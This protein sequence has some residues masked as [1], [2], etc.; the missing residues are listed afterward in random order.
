MTIT[1]S[2]EGINAEATFQHEQLTDAA[3]F[4]QALQVEY[5]AALASLNLPDSNPVDWIVTEAFDQHLDDLTECI[6]ADPESV[7]QFYQIAADLEKNDNTHNPVTVLKAWI[8]IFTV[9]PETSSQLLES[10]RGHFKDEDEFV[11]TQL[12]E[13]GFSKDA[14]Y[15]SLLQI[16]GAWDKLN[17]G[18]DYGFSGG[19]VFRR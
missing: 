11:S 15:W 5:S 9:L 4:T 7:I 8:A 3:T 16:E 13:S 18:L 2:F 17:M 1:V 19:F 6:D 14:W 10:S 12:E